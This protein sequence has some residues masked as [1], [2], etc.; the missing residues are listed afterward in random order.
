M[1][2]AQIAIINCLSCLY[3]DW[4]D[5]SEAIMEALADDDV[6]SMARFI[7]E[8]G[9]PLYAA[10]LC[11]YFRGRRIGDGVFTDVSDKLLRSRGQTCLTGH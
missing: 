2:T 5:K 8:H 6:T 3:N 11:N 10:N 9:E 7:A 1:Y 4:P